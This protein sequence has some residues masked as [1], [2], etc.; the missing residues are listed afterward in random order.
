MTFLRS[1]EYVF[2]LTLAQLPGC[3][4]AVYLVERLEQQMTMGLYRMANG[5]DLDVLL[6]PESLGR[7]LRLHPGGLPHPAAHPRGWAWPA[8]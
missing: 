4:S 1:Y 5:S 7:P 2:I 3:F 6:R 8:G